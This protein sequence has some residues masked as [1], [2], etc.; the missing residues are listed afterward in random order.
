VRSARRASHSNST[1]ANALAMITIMEAAPALSKR[2]R[3]LYAACQK[4]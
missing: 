1:S 3:I 4:K 2:Y